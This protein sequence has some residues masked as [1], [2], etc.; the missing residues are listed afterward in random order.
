MAATAKREAAPP[1]PVPVDRSGAGPLPRN[2]FA[3]LLFVA[4]LVA[5][6]T[7]ELRVH[8]SFARRFETAVTGRM[9]RP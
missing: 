8:A 6:V 5:G 3:V 2:S 9:E 1:R 7:G 4:A